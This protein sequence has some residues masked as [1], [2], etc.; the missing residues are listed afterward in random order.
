MARPAAYRHRKVQEEM[1]NPLLL[2]MKLKNKWEWHIGICNWIN[3]FENPFK[4]TLRIRD[5]GE[6]FV[7]GYPQTCLFALGSQARTI[8]FC[9]SSTLMVV[10]STYKTWV[11]R[12][13]S[14]CGTALK[15][16]LCCLR[17]N[18]AG[19][20]GV[21]SC[22]CQTLIRHEWGASF[23]NV[24]LHSKSSHIAWEQNRAGLAPQSGQTSLRVAMNKIL[25]HK[26]H[27][28]EIIMLLFIHLKT[29]KVLNNHILY[30]KYKNL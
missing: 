15:V 8:L 5:V 9:S 4:N 7:F 13:S 20:C 14:R 30:S 16:F 26:R 25:P 10:P 12:F 19:F 3:T 2:K 21:H 24:E 6:D 27:L 18:R 23:A 28:Q 29:G 11:E 17:T 22:L 1:K